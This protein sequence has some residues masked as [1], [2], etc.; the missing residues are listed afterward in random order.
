MAKNKT[1]E[2]SVSVEDF[3]NAVK[4]EIKRT[5]SFSLIE[6]LKKQTAFEPI[7]WG[8]SIVGFGRY[9]Y[10][11]ESGHEGES[12]LVGFS[13]RAAAITL[14][15]SAEFEKREAL[16]EKLGKYKTDKGCIYV[17]KLADINLEILQKMIANH[18]E[19][20]EKT[21]STT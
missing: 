10:R 4:D 13:P 11:Y 3:I 5:D 6:L 19:Y 21:Y 16:L 14:Y 2:T 18:I 8:P 12:P 15:L 20:I 17:K 1:T 7:M 9:H